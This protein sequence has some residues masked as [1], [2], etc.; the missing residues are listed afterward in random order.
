MALPIRRR[1]TGSEVTAWDPIAEFD[2]WSEQVRSL[3]GFGAPLLNGAGFMPLA[4]IEETEDAFLVEVDLPGVKKGDID[5]EIAGRRLSVS[6][7]RKERERK[8]VLR[9][10]T[11]NV[12]HFHYEVTLPT[13]VDAEGVSASLE[14]GTLT[15]R[16]PKAVGERPRRIAVS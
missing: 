4:D 13:D 7:E 9:G 11:R 14:E 3:F 2:R 16:V 8:G 15:V 5:V 1:D 10:K 6:G 12:G